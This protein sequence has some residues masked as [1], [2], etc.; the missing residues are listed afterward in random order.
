VIRHPQ[1]GPTGNNIWGSVVA[2]PAWHDIALNLYSLM[3][4]VPEPGSTPDT[5]AK[6]QGPTGWNCAFMP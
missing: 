5:L 3:N 4:I 1:P 2:A 6:L